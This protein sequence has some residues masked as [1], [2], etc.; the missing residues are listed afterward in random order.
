VGGAPATAGEPGA[1]GEPRVRMDPQA[2]KELLLGAAR[3]VFAEKGYAAS[4]LAEIAERAHVNK[5]LLYYYYPDGRAELFT[6]V[7]RDLLAELTGVIRSAVSGPVNTARRIERL[8]QALIGFFEAQPDAFDILFRDPYGVREPEIV[9]EAV[10]VQVA[11]AKE[12][13]TLL[14]PSGVP[15]NTLL[16]IANG[17]VAYVVKV[18]EMTVAG[19]ID[20]EDAL[21]ACMTCMLG[22]MAQIGMGS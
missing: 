7:L 2:R 5:R 19:E 20:S 8:V 6:A 16:A 13:T 21:D 9:L 4:G 1:A 12:I 10:G 3:E 14:A 11:V 22:V 15:T 18:I 17:T